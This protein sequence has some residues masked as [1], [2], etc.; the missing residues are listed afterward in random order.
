MLLLSMLSIS[1]QSEGGKIYDQHCSN[2]H[3]AKGEGFAALIPAFTEEAFRTD[4]T[5]LIC[6]IISGVQDSLQY[7]FMPSYGYLSDIQIAN[8]LNFIAKN[9]SMATTAFTAKEIEEERVIC[10]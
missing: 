10:K 6:N 4:R 8:V 1:C 9:G 5:R 7:D 3:M 2:C